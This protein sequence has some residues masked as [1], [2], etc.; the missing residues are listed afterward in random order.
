MYERDTFIQVAPD[1]PVDR[2]VV[3]TS[4]RE[5]KPVHVLQFELLTRHPYRFTRDE[6]LFEVRVA[7]KGISK[8]E[9]R[10]RRDEIRAAL[11]AKPVPCLRTCVLAKKYGWGIHVDGS[12]KVALCGR[13]TEEYRRLAETEGLTLT[14]AMRSKRA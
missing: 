8:A 13:E 6:L 11:F 7:Q 2:G 9:A 4:R 14:T 12:G 10:A 5:P 1:C 3:P